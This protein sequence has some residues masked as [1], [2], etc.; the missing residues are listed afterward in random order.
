MSRL[1]RPQAVSCRRGVNFVPA[2]GAAVRAGAATGAN[3]AG[4]AI[5]RCDRSSRYSSARTRRWSA[6]SRSRLAERLFALIQLRRPYLR[7][8]EHRQRRRMHRPLRFP[9]TGR[10]AAGGGAAG[11]TAGTAGVATGGRT[12]AVYA[13]APGASA[14]PGAASTGG[15]T[16]RQ[17]AGGLELD[18]D[19]VHQRRIYLA[20]LFS[21]SENERGV[22]YDVDDP[23]D[24][25]AAAVDDVRDIP[26]ELQRS[27]D[28]RAPQ[29]MI[30][31]M[32]V[33]PA[34]SGE[35]W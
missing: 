17:H 12:G 11:S 7:L 32:A 30:D 15:R 4:G 35:R 23:G 31:V 26:V 5:G 9:G 20:A 6:N 34:S 3:A 2:C 24:P 27:T 28:G 18:E 29:P 10:T 33:S 13:S 21:V 14:C 25:P 8:L 19:I 22:T 16:P 1:I